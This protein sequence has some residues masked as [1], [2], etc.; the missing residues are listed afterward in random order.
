M[1]IKKNEI[2]VLNAD[3][4]NFEMSSLNYKRVYRLR[5]EKRNLHLPKQL[6]LNK[7]KREKTRDRVEIE[8]QISFSYN[9]REV[10]DSTSHI[11]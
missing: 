3:M 9:S 10:A 5:D 4:V 2:D 8:Y 6:H 1:R 11:D 7:K